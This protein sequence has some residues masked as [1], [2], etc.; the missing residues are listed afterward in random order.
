LSVLTYTYL[1][2]STIHP[3]IPTI[4]PRTNYRRDVSSGVV[5]FVWCSVLVDGWGVSCWWCVLVFVLILYYI[6]YYILLLLYIYYYYTYTILF[7]FS[8]FILFYPNLSSPILLFPSILPKSISSSSSLPS[9]ILLLFWSQYS[10]YT[11]RYLHI[12]IYIPPVPTIWPRTFY[13]SGWLRCDVFNSWES[14]LSLTPHV[15]SEW[16]VEVWCV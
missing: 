15:L 14:C 3:N 12:L 11:C 16:M 1:Y 8:S 7:L 4:W 2:Y 10:F 9:L 13:R 5:L 6:L